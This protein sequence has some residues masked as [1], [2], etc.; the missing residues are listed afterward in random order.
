MAEQHRRPTRPS[1]RREVLGPGDS[2]A[3]IDHSTHKST[4]SSKVP[5]VSS[6]SSLPHNQSLAANGALDVHTTS[7]TASMRQERLSSAAPESQRASKRYSEISNC[8]T[9]SGSGRKSFVGRWQL[10]KTIGQ[11][12]CSTVRLVRHKDTGQIG[13]AKIISRKMAETVRAQSLAN[14][15][16][17]PDKSLQ[18][19]VAAGKAMPP[20]PPGLL[21]EIAIMKLLDHRNIVR[22]YDVWENHNELYLIMEYVE[23]GELFHYIEECRGLGEQES[24]YIF[25]QIVAALLYCHRMHIHHRDLKPE[26]ILLDRENIQVKLVDFGMAAL[27]PEGKKLTTACGSPHYAAPE[28]IK[29]RPYDGARAD[30]WSCGVILYVMLTGMTPFN[31]DQDRNLG[32]MYRA[33]AEADYYMPPELSRD[34]QDLLRKIFVPDPRRRITMEQIWE[35]PLLHK[36]DEEWGYTGPLASKEAWVGPSPILEDWTVTRED[37]VDKEILRNMRT[38]WHSVPQSV[39]VKKLVSN[40]PNQ[41]KLF[42][43]ALLKH[44][45]ENLENYLGGADAISYSASDYQHNKNELKDQ[46][47]MPNQKQQSQSQYSIMNDEHLRTPQLADD[48]LPSDGTHDPYRSSRYQTTPNGTPYTKVTVHRRGESNGSRKAYMQHSLRHP[49][50]LRVEMLKK[51]GQANS[52]S[53]LVKQE[54]R[55]SMTRSISKASTSR[56]S[57]VSSVWPS[58]PPVM[59]RTVSSHKHKRKVSFSH[60]R[61][62]SQAAVSTTAR[63]TPELQAKARFSQLMHGSPTPDINSPSHRV[64]S[65]IRSRKEKS[66]AP[67]PRSRPRNNSTGAARTDIRKASSELEQACEEA[68]N[69]C[70]FSSSVFTSASATEK[71]GYETPPS[72]V[73]KRDS[74]SSIKEHVA[75]RPLPALPTDTP[76][77]FITRTLEETRHKLAARSA[78]EGNDGSAK[79]EQVLANLDRIMPGD[80]RTVS[81]PDHHAMDNRAPLPIISEEGR[82]EGSHRRPVEANY[83]YRSVTAPIPERTVRMVQPSSPA[84]PKSPYNWRSVNEPVSEVSHHTAVDRSRLTVPTGDPRMVRKKT[85]D[86]DIP[87]SQISS[88]GSQEGTVKKKSSWFRKWKEPTTS[89][90]DSQSRSRSPMPWNETVGQPVQPSVLN[91]DNR[92]PQLDLTNTQ[93]PAPN[94]S[95]SNEFPMRRESKGFSKW[96]GRK[97]DS[98]KLS[99]PSAATMNGPLS[100]FSTGPL[101]PLPPTTPTSAGGDNATRSWFSRFLRLRPEVRTLAFNVPRTRARTELVRMLREWQRHGIK[102]LT[103]FPQDNAITASIDKVNSLGIKPVTFRIELFVVLKNGRKAGLSLARCSQMR[104]AASSFRKVIEVLEQVGRDRGL[105]IDDESQWNELCGILA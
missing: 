31:Y 19:L 8:T 101:S 53:S 104:G 63:F 76:N 86:S 102:D 69:R 89:T 43:A 32:V 82:P 66:V 95:S 42:Y 87:L 51:Q 75:P 71:A 12:G 55:K 6:P 2:R 93:M 38:L 98:E 99:P 64:E 68:F 25:R 45:E 83:R 54:Y 30:V 77:T 24:V 11:G 105:L 56:N 18:D 52:S 15:A 62:S 35:H 37:E 26:N 23:G 14:L 81:A 65:A 73:S 78:S 9:A 46:P 48:D 1:T 28:V 100:P 34:A 88:R 47:P 40:E 61:K 16:E 59:P 84:T 60:H 85:S 96:F 4:R 33:I 74:G 79:I 92:P 13:A 7:P 10:G 90:E 58:S 50:A 67:A 91:R 39:L 97:R 72:S 70:S 49:N 44:R 94:S 29:S 103:Y 36:F 21:R 3:N 41:E 57:V 80:K 17:M 27:Q 20:P 22:L 5:E